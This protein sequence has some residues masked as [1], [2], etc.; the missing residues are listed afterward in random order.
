MTYLLE[1]GSPLN[2]TVEKIEQFGK[3]L[4]LEFKNVELF[5]LDHKNKKVMVSNCFDS[6]KFEGRSKDI[7]LIYV[8]YQGDEGSNANC[9]AAFVE[10][11]KSHDDIAELLAS[12]FSYGVESYLMDFDEATED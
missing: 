12:I 1:L 11:H 5:S 9:V 8:Y 2:A 6:A 3:E 7:C 4:D 10:N